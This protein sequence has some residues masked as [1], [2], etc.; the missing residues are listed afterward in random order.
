MKTLLLASIGDYVIKKGLKLLFPD[1]SRMKLAWIT[2]ATKGAVNRENLEKHKRLLEK[3]G[4]NFTEIDIEGKNIGELE[5]LLGGMD[6]VLVEGGNAFYLLKAVRESGFDQVVKKLLDRG[7]VYVGASAGSYVACPTIEM[8]TW[9]KPGEEKNNFGVTDLA[10]MN[11][12]PFLVKA[13]Y[14]PEMK[15]FLQ[16]KIAKAGYPVKIITDEQAILVKDDIIEL[17]GEGEEL[18]I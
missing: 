5:L 4:Y 10:A 14:V 7:V 12:V 1:V 11:L 6:A 17:V 18:R 15:E 3:E 9:K 13:H 16:E 2:T 8:S